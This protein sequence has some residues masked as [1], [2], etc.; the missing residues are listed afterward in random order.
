ARPDRGRP[1]CRARAQSRWGA[2]LG[3]PGALAR[4]VDRALERADA[5]P[6]RATALILGGVVIGV[7]ALVFA[8]TSLGGSSG[9]KSATASTATTGSHVS[10]AQ[11]KS[12]SAGSSS[13][14]TAGAASPAET[15]V[16][17][18]NGTE[19]SGLA[20]RVSEQLHQSGYSQATALNGRPPGANQVT[21]V[22]YASG[23]RGDAAGV[24][25]ALGVGQAQPM[26]ATVSS[27][28]GSATV[29]VIVGLD[30]AS[31]ASSESPAGG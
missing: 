28:A 20:H 26:E 5:H 13:K 18:L 19:T 6:G 23:H 12:S 22:E 1:R 27:L 3:A 25:S 31:T 4:H 16:A 11:G 21:V 2:A 24:A 10:K 15:S 9:G 29:V 14:A 8:L 30:K 17:V 7:A